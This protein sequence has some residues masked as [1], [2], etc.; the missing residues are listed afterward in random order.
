LFI[1]NGAIF[2]PVL[3]KNKIDIRIIFVWNNLPIG[4]V[5]SFAFQIETVILLGDVS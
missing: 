5:F 1:E 2:V 3:T 4:V